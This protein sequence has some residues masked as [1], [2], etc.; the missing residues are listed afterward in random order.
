M[1][2]WGAAHA[3]DAGATWVTQA[4]LASIASVDLR[5]VQ[6]VSVSSAFV[7]GSGHT[8]LRTQD[9]GDSWTSLSTPRPSLD[10]QALFFRAAGDG[11]LVG[12]GVNRHCRMHWAMYMSTPQKLCI[13]HM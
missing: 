2:C 10:L 7:V 4:P 9:G 12:K 11:W 1:L 3:A 13:P 6:A 8:V 5:A